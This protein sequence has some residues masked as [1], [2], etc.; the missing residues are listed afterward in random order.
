MVV[1][2][3]DGL[4]LVLPGIGSCTAGGEC[5]TVM[6]SIDRQSGVGPQVYDAIAGAIV[7]LELKPG[8]FLSEKE[9]A[10]Q[11]GISRT[12]VR[13]ALIKLRGKGLVE[14]YPQVGTRV[15]RIDRDLVFESQFI[16]EA[17]EC[18]CA[19][20]AT[21]TRSAAEVAELRGIVRQQRQCARRDDFD[22]F[23]MLDE[24][25]HQR[26]AD[27]SGHATVWDTIRSSKLYL[28]RV[29]RLSLPMPSLL[30]H[31]IGQHAEIVAGIADKDVAAA[32]D[33][34]RR[35]TR[36]VLRVVPQLAQDFPEFFTGG[37]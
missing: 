23:Y 27:L 17:L 33:A 1:Y 35:H 37:A 16:R 4:G 8:Q 25:L 6:S 7:K 13:E 26:V 5:V 15:A 12:P 11:L 20:R 9:L 36:E 28:D 29:R 31:L 32:E 3:H 19:R 22:A 10:L 24:R 18:A 2:Y 21:E 30:D 14:I 34:V